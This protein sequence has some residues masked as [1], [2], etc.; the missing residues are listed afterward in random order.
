[1]KSEKNILIAFILNLSFSVFEFL[2]GILT[3]S[4]AI[5]SDAV[6]DIGDAV[7][8]GIAFALEKKSKRPPDEKYT[9]G[10]IGYSIVGSLITTFILFLGSIAVIY[11]AIERIIFPNAINYDGMIIFAVIGVTINLI[12]AIITRGDSSLNQKAINLHMIEDVLGWIIVLIGAIVMRFTD[13]CIL[14]SLMSIGVALFILTHALKSIF[15]ALGLL[16][17]KTPK[18]IDIADLKKHLREI[19]GVLDVHHIHVWSI[20]THNNYATMHVV[21]TG[22]AHKIKENL[23]KELS[24]RNI[25]HSTFEFE[26]K[27]EHCHNKYC[28]VDTRISEHKHHH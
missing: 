24:N 17:Y 11:N 3:G 9:Y 27:D 21:V 22:D 15:E 5:L 2:G 16:L 14:D 25:T 28:H 20:D 6:H 12:A 18:D 4:V 1:M 10:Y 26:E 8:I 23:R 7:S 13:F 19:D